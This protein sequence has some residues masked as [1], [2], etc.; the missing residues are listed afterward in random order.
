LAF[1][2]EKDPGIIGLT[3]NVKFE[4][5]RNGKWYHFF[6]WQFFLFLYHIIR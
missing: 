5:L 2:N 1:I 6:F 3:P 4:M